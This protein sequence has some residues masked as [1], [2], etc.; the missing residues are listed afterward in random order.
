MC[1][2]SSDGKIRVFDLADVPVESADDAPAELHPL[3][4]YDSKGSRLTCMAM[5]DG[6]DVA[7]VANVSGKRKREE[8]DEVSADEWAEQHNPEGEISEE[9]DASEE[10]EEEEEIEGEKEDEEEVEE[11]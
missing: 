6:D 8:R 5:A 11:D 1:T 2:I 7:G 10:G 4:E 3:T 9:E